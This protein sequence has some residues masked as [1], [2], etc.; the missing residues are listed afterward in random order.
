M[1]TD[2]APERSQSQAKDVVFVFDK[3][4]SMSGDKIKQAK[5]AL[6]YCLNQ[7]GPDDRFALIVFGTEVDMLTDGLVKVSDSTRSRALEGVGKIEASGGTAIYDALLKACSL[8]SDSKNVRMVVFMTDGQPTVGPG[9]PNVIAEAVRTNNAA[10]ARMFVFGVGDKLNTELLDRLAVENRGTQEYIGEKEDIEEKVSTFFAKM[11]KPAFTDVSVTC[12]GLQLVDIYPRIIPDIFNRDQ[13]LLFARY[14]GTGRHTLTLSGNKGGVVRNFRTEIDFDGNERNRFVAP[15][16]AH[17][18]VAY[19]MEQIRINGAKTELQDEIVTLGKRF[20][21][22]TPYT[23]FLV[24]EDVPVEHRRAVSG[25]SGRFE[26]LREGADAVNMSR[27]VSGAKG[28]SMAPS[29]VGQSMVGFGAAEEGKQVETAVRRQVRHVADKVFYRQSDGFFYDSVYKEGDKDTIVTVKAFS[30]EYFSLFDK[31][32]GV[33]K[34]L[35]AKINMV[36]C[37]DGKIYRIQAD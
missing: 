29:T 18:K 19:L 22:M 1:H 14:R 17:R 34:Y 9:D 24:A 32:P 2:R 26:R 31:H 35:A 27:S 15:V 25:F 16:W 7:I 8:L 37:L 10:K 6:T 3:S 21:I 23:S 36:I 30:E 4:G 12:D 11:D 20:G 28:A 5:G 13:L 33:G